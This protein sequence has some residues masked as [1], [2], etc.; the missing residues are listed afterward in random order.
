MVGNMSLP[1]T[2][3]RARLRHRDS[4]KW[5]KYPEDVLPL[6]VAD[7]DYPPPPAVVA[8]LHARLE[9]GLGYHQ[10]AGDPDLTRLLRAQLHGQG[11]PELPIGGL[12]FL[13]GVVPGLYAAVLGLTSPGD[14]VLTFTPIY[15]PFVSSIV[16]HGRRVVGVPLL[17]SAGH[18]ELDW[19]ALE[20]AVTPATRLLMLCHPHNPTGRVWTE[21]ELRG[22]ADFALRHRLWVVSDELHAQLSFQGPHRPLVSLD[23]RLSERTL[24]LTGPCKTYNTAGLGIGAAFSH[25]LPLLERF[26]AASVG[27][28]GHPSALSVTMWRAALGDDGA[29]LAAVLAQLK[30]N[31][32]TLSAWVARELPWA[33]YSPPEA[34]YLALLDLRAHPRAAE[35]QTYLLEEAR[36]ALNDGPTFG[37]PAR[38]QE[39][40]GYVR[41]NFA[42]TPDV[43]DE[44]L[45]RLAR[46][47]RL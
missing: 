21:A 1:S 20:A 34:T 44:A 28:M 46:A 13:P 6:W 40:Q 24:T 10:L 8:A 36:V 42:T 19:A 32:D 18:Y 41:L 22:L 2:A 37:V 25:S 31:R 12:K 23:P 16:D 17:F 15:P 5:T 9:H 45:A 11:V 39:Y 29:W 3:D 33:G 4:Y 27:V 14:E 30:T 47:L 43:L 7:M 26:R 35:M 38:P